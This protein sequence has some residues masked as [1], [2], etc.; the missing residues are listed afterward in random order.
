M[1]GGIHSVSGKD[2]KVET[3]F[4]LCWN[5]EAVRYDTTSARVDKHGG[6]SDSK[7]AQSFLLP[8]PLCGLP[9]EGVAQHRGGLPTSNSQIKET[10]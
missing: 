3:I 4:S 2:L 9:P 6:K 10:P 5:L 1:W 7:Q 8:G